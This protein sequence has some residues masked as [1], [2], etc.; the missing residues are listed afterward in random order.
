MVGTACRKLLACWNK[1]LI[2][3]LVDVALRSPVDVQLQPQKNGCHGTGVAGGRGRR[4]GLIR[5]AVL[6]GSHPGLRRR[7]LALRYIGMPRVLDGQQ[8]R[9]QRHR[10]GCDRRG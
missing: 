6:L 10:R 5:V 9:R 3:T 7:A 1:P 8:L 2:H 4:E